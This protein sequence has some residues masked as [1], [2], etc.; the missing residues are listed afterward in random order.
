MAENTDL[1]LA[2]EVYYPDKDEFSKFYNVPS[3]VLPTK[4]GI[5]EYFSKNTNKT[6]NVLLLSTTILG[7]RPKNTSTSIWSLEHLKNKLNNTN[8]AGYTINAQIIEL[9][10]INFAPC[11]G[12]YSK[13]KNSCAWPCQITLKDPNDRLNVVYWGLVDWADIVIVGTSIRYGQA[14][15]LY[16]K[17]VERLTCVHNQL[18]LNDHNLIMDKIAA[19]VITGAQDNIQSVAGGMMLFW[20]ELGFTFAGHSYVGWSRGWNQEHTQSN[21]IAMKANDGYLEDLER[22]AN[23]AIEAKIRLL[24]SPLALPRPS[25]AMSFS[26]YEVRR[27]REKEKSRSV[28]TNVSHKLTISEKSEI[29]VG[30]G[31]YIVKHKDRDCKIS[32]I[33]DGS[34]KMFHVGGRHILVIRLGDTVK[35][36]EGI[37][38]HAMVQF[39]DRNLHEKNG[40]LNIVCDAHWA[41]FDTKTGQPKNQDDFTSRYNCKIEGL[42]ELSCT[43]D[44]NG[45]I[46]VTC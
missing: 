40:D 29:K 25:S 27:H 8:F 6:L 34:Q 16:Y 13:S 23:D 20:S 28:S 33:K 43:I 31:E 41:L 19:F 36:F 46:S 17:L 35:A 1:R 39:T 44:E 12:N 24:E 32:D 14:S 22:L 21:L 18:T 10:K 45:T 38:P 4:K 5:H 42:E 26:E 7:S 3:H 30:E 2:S 9:E 37:C 11:E 15:S